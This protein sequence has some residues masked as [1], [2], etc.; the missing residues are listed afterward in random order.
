MKPLPKV[1]LS[2][3]LLLAGAAALP[4]Q[5]F[6]YSN[7]GTVAPTVPLYA[8][9]TG[10]LTAELNAYFAGAEAGGEDRV[11]M[12]DLTTGYVGAWTLDNRTSQIGQQFDLGPV[13]AG[14]HIA[15]DIDNSDNDRLGFN[16]Y[17]LSSDPSRST[18][19]FN[20]G[21]I[22]QNG[23]PQNTLTY[24]GMEDVADLRFVDWDYNDDTF[25]LS[26]L[27]TTAPVPEPATFALLG[28]GLAGLAGFV[29]R[30]SLN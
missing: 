9:S 3:S 8:A 6:V 11:R 27:T 30:R 5:S 12:V 4:A 28:S 15:F 17:I 1:L 2:V 13:N 29:R 23:D 16:N 19:G 25:L 20:Y 7:R 24:V 26:G 22:A 18:T 21:F 10:Q 14:D